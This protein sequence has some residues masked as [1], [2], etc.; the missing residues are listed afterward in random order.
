MWKSQQKDQI[1]L[2]ETHL[3]LKTFLDE[4][5]GAEHAHCL[6]REQRQRNTAHSVLA[7]FTLPQ[8]S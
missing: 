7:A 1:G 5:L 6:P 2:K 3:W 4:S 8:Q